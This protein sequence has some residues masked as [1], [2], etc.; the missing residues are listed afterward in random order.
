M[1]TIN[2]NSTGAE[3]IKDINDNFDECARGSAVADGNVSVAVP[4]QG[5]ELKASTG[6]VDGYWC[7][8]VTLTIGQNVP[9]FTYTDDNF[10]KYLHTPC[11]LSMIGNK[12]K[13]VSLPTGSTLTIFCYD[14]AFTLLG[15][16]VVNAVANIPAGTAY[17]KMQVYNS[18]GFSKAIALDVVLAAQPKWIKNTYAPLTPQFHNYE[19]KP[20]KLWDTNYT[21]VHALPTGATADADNTRYH[22]NAF[23]LLPPNYSPDGEPCKFV[24]FFSGDACMWF[25]AHNPFIGNTSGKVSASVYEQNFKYLNNMGYAVV[26][27]GGY[28]SMWSGEYGATRSGHWASRISPAYMASVRGLY[29]FLMANYNFN[30]SP[31][32]AAKSAGG[33]MLLNTA[34]TLPFPVRAAAGFSISVSMAD[35]MSQCMLSAQK[36]WQKRLG[37]SNWDSFVLN[38]RDYATIAD[39]DRATKKSGATADQIADAN[40]LIANKDIYRHL[41]QFVAMSDM[42][43]SDYLDAILLYDP[44]ND[45]EPPQA[46]TDLIASSHKNMRV[47]VKL[48]CATKDPATPYSWHKLYADWVSRCNGICELRSYTGD[49]GDHGTFCGG[50]A[51]VANNLPTPYGGTMSGVN[52]GIVEAVEW[53]KRW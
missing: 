45:E 47:P 4:M 9:T 2:A 48:W 50:T 29:D 36:S 17:V 14:E 19:C 53:F 21:V 23:V 8:P 6:Y 15:G 13:S 49:D 40:R 44:F 24:I 37:C 5:G 7:E 39:G 26:S 1:K 12:V 27:L 35:I 10:T 46:L 43:Y 51:H 42:D 38:N 16:G 18:S 31:Y 34:A 25:M 22:D 20:P 28:T 52:I 33:A 41:D 11:Y 3:F 30:P 32:I